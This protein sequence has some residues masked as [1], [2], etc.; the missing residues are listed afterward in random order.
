MASPIV[1]YIVL[2]KDLVDKLKWPIGA[3]IA[4]AC[5][6]CTAVM[7]NFREETTTQQYLADIERMHKVVLEANNEESLMALAEKLKA[8]NVDHKLWIEQPEDI[9]TCIATRPY[10][11]D[12]I[13]SHFKKFKLMK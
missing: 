5:H 2:R 8:E 1:Q 7:H 9:P 4:Q 6:A 12:L 11:K 3:L 13:Q 10:Q